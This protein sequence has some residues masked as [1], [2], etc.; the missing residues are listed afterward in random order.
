M[1]DFKSCRSS[2]QLLMDSLQ[3]VHVSE[4]KLAYPLPRAVGARMTS[5]FSNFRTF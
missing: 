2:E 1:K 4:V 5:T 3:A